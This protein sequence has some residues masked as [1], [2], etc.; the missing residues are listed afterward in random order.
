MGNYRDRSFSASWPWCSPPI[1]Q[2]WQTSLLSVLHKYWICS[3]GWHMHGLCPPFSSIKFLS[4]CVW[5]KLLFSVISLWWFVI[6]D[7]NIFLI[8]KHWVRVLGKTL[9]K[10]LVYNITQII[11][12][13]LYFE[14]FKKKGSQ[15]WVALMSPAILSWGWLKWIRIKVEWSWG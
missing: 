7:P 10:A 6:I 11:I 5:N 3:S 14:H 1:R 8:L 9:K 12:I 13:K 2:S 4:R 15:D